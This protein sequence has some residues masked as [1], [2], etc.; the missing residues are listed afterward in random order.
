MS[1]RGSSSMSALILEAH[2][3][4][5]LSSVAAICGGFSPFWP[6][7]G[8]FLCLLLVGASVVSDVLFRWDFLMLLPFVLVVSIPSPWFSDSLGSMVSLVTGSPVGSSRCWLWLCSVALVLGY[9]CF[10]PLGFWSGCQFFFQPLSLV[11]SYFLSFCMEELHFCWC[12]LTCS[13]LWFP[14]AT[15]S[16]YGMSQ[17]CLGLSHSGLEVTFTWWSPVGSCLG[18]D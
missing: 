1:T 2:S 12:L 7:A 10:S 14:F 17:G 9:A 18:F 13:E 3:L 16:P 11:S 15:W 8:L 6:R 4:P 5:A